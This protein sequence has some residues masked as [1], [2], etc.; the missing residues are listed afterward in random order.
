MVAN[1]VLVGV[2]LGAGA[3]QYPMWSY[4]FPYG[5]CDYRYL[6]GWDIL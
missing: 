3:T 5:E 6:G 1:L 2:F 4:L